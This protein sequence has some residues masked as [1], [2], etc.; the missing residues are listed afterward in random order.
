MCNFFDTTGTGQ[1]CRGYRTRGEGKV[2][3]IPL[4]RSR[5]SIRTRASRSKVYDI[6]LPLAKCV[7]IGP[8]NTSAGGRTV[9]KHLRVSLGVITTGSLGGMIIVR[10]H[11][12]NPRPRVPGDY[13][14]QLGF[15]CV[16][17][18]STRRISIGSHVVVGP[19]IAI[20]R[21]NSALNFLRPFIGSKMR[22]V[23]P[24]R[25]HLNFSVGHSPL[26][27][28]ESSVV[29]V[30]CRSRRG[31]SVPVSFRLC[32]VREGLR[33]EIATSVICNVGRGAPCQMSDVYLT[34][35]CIHSPVHFLSCSVV[36]GPVR[37]DQCTQAEE[38][39][40]D[41]SRRHVGL[42]FLM[43]R[44]GLSPSSAAGITRLRGLGQ[45]LSHCVNTSTKVAKTVVRNSTSPRKNVIAGRH[46]Y[47]RHTRCLHG[48]L[49]T[50]P[51]LRG[52]H[53]DNRVGA[54]TGI[55]S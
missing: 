25:H 27:R 18:L 24:G 4:Q 9:G 43:K 54:A 8:S 45:G 31:S 50:F 39:R 32:P 26:C 7:V 11:P 29:N 53:H 52:T 36:R 21:A 40:L 46:L 10:G 49:C 37:H 12:P 28:C 38:T 30:V 33:C 41:G 6:L 22:F 20:L 35:K 1:F 16:F 55:T 42:A 5:C 44:T 2:A 23:G 17:P 51:T 48:R 19:I 3:C 14:G 13:N 15:R 47:G 34:R